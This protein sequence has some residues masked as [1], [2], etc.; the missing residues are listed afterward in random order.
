MLAR[1][2][3]SD[4]GINRQI[5]PG[6]SIVTGEVLPAA[7]TTAAITIS[8]QQLSSGLINRTGLGGAGTDTIDSAANLIANIL[9]GLGL[10]GVQDQTAWRCIWYNPSAS[11]ITVTATANTGV[12]VTNGTVNA[13]SVKSFL[14]TIV[15][16]TPART[17]N[18][19]STNTSPI[20]TGVS[21]ADCAALGVGQIVT[22]ATVGLQGQTIIG[23]DIA[24]G[25]V[26]FSGNANATQAVSIAASPQVTL[27][28]LGQGLV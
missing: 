3:V 4:G 9:Q 18:G 8:G 14:C 27:L 19:F 2:Q 1:S 5:L 21:Q 15:D 13:A 24:K 12:T 11:V 17:F 10:T 20:V 16:G 26:T 25:A 23:I 28:G 22:N 6:D 7:I